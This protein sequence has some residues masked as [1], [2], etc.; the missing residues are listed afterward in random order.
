MTSST[1]I[2]FIHSGLMKTLRKESSM[3]ALYEFRNKKLK[4][5]LTKSWRHTGFIDEGGPVVQEG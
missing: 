1:F 5:F 4:K 3:D 2:A